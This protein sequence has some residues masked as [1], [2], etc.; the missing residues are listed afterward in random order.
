MLN[1]D[2]I[3]LADFSICPSL[4]IFS[5]RWVAAMLS[6]MGIFVANAL[7]LMFV[8]QEAIADVAADSDDDNEKLESSSEDETRVGRLLQYLP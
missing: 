1:L 3:N 4:E 6:C 7:F 2:P 8:Q 5:Q